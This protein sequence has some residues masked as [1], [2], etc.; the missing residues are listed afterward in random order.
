[1]NQRPRWDDYYL[2]IAQAVKVRG[3]CARRQVGAVVVRQH[4]IVATGY[5]GAP[6]GH[7]SCLDGACP[8]ATVVVGSGADYAATGCVVIHAE[9]NAIIR[10]GWDRCS[11]ATLYVTDTPCMM[12]TPLMYAANLNKVV[13]LDEHGNRQSQQLRDIE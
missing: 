4:W 9:Q 1:M 13:W 11:G 8:R 6:P 7:L 10:A 12:C 3:E 2:G 5:N